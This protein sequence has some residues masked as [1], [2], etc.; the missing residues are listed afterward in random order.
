MAN[1]RN[2]DEVP[3][4]SFEEGRLAFLGDIPLDAEK[5]E[6]AVF[7]HNQ[8]FKSVVLYWPCDQRFEP[9]GWRHQ[10]Y[11]IAE[12]LS[13]NDAQ[14]ATK[15]LPDVVFKGRY[16]KTAIPQG[17]KQ[18]SSEP[19]APTPLAE[20]KSTS[21][22]SRH[23]NKADP[24]VIR[25]A[26]QELKYPDA[27]SYS[28]RW[29]KG[30]VEGAVVARM[31]QR[32]EESNSIGSLL[33][34]DGGRD[35]FRSQ[36][37]P[38]PSLSDSK[39]CSSIWTY[40]TKVE[41]DDRKIQRI[42]LRELPLHLKDGWQE[43][44]KGKVRVEEGTDK[45]KRKILMVED[46]NPADNPKA[47]TLKFFDIATTI[48]Q[49]ADAITWNLGHVLGATDGT[50]EAPMSTS[51]AFIPPDVSCTDMSSAT[52]RGHQQRYTRPAKIGA[53]WGDYDRFREWQLHGRRLNVDWVEDKQWCPVNAKQVQFRLLGEN[54]ETQGDC[55]T[56]DSVEFKP[57][58]SESTKLPYSLRDKL[59]EA[60]APRAGRGVVGRGGS[61]RGGPGRGD[62]TRGGSARAQ[63]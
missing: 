23:T 40:V 1:V 61:R 15:K 48:S 46:V 5:Q 10:G 44:F 31:K 57:T 22:S 30:D 17:R 4:H 35:R 3:K 14:E 6:I 11:C 41:S 54:G 37:V 56:A 13:R 47:D 9:Y 50:K 18:P 34:R 36:P 62:A 59:E 32:E 60:K 49:K 52:S 53:G 21:T 51:K 63:W 45:D 26:L 24:A 42:T 25:Q 29:G 2:Q 43:W 55:V 39:Y 58:L 7:I 27:Y 16:L 28:G 19:V 33:A 38:S 8:G 12:F 20:A